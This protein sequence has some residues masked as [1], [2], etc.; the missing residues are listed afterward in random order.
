MTLFSKVF[1]AVTLTASMS[2]AQKQTQSATV[3]KKTP[4]TAPPTNEPPQTGTDIKGTIAPSPTPKPMHFDA[5]A[6]E[7][8][9]A[10]P[11]SGAS[12]SRPLFGVHAA[13]GFPHVTT[14][15]LDLVTASRTWGFALIGGAF[16]ADG[17]ESTKI[18]MKN[19]EVQARYH[20]WA[21]AFYVGLGYGNHQVKIEKT[22]NIQGFDAKA[23][24]NVK[25]NYFKPQLGWIWQYDAGLSVGFEL[26]YL[27]PSGNTT[28]FSS[29]APGAITGTQEYLNLE[30]DV[31]DNGDKFGKMGLPFVTLLRLGW[32]F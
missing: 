2:W 8:P 30:K 6:A 28:D 22:E 21:S 14:V 26:G 20:P 17:P 16:N 7:E 18:D 24:A 10:A 12:W 25:A 5:P 15:G 9:K 32:M 29:N 23:E 19:T 4:P 1:L 31:K 3:E 11:T 13:L 27:A